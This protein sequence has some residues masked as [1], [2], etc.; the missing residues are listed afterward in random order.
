[1][2]SSRYSIIFGKI[3][4]RKLSLKKSGLTG[5]GHVS[6]YGLSLDVGPIAYPAVR[7]FSIHSQSHNSE[8][9]HI[10]KDG[11][12]IMV[13]IGKKDETS[14]TAIAAATVKID[15]TIAKLIHENNVK[16]GDVLTIA[17]IA[18]IL[19]AK[20]TSEIIPLCHN[21]SLASIKVN[22]HL[23]LPKE[24]VLIQATVEC[25]GQTGVEMEALTAVSVA[26]LTVYDMCKA[27][28][29]KIIIND[30]HLISKTGGKSGDFMQEE[31]VLRDYNRNPTTGTFTPFVGSV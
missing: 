4:K 13:D 17:E 7:L 9:T 12:A 22:C 6:N 30:I 16:K 31:I 21:I 15:S 28:S 14:R 26:A 29:K 2:L 24:E 5:N 18:G 3:G 8:L 25:R 23:D 1:M 11:K 10:G 20:K 19:G 27:V